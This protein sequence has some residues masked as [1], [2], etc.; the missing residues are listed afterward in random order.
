LG[1]KKEDRVRRKTRKTGHL[2][3]S[4]ART[5]GGLGLPTDPWWEEAFKLGVERVAAT[6]A[7]NSLDDAKREGIVGPKT[8]DR[9]RQVYL[10]KLSAIEG[11]TSKWH[12]EFPSFSEPAS[13]S[14]MMSELTEA[15]GQPSVSQHVPSNR[16]EVEPDLGAPSLTASRSISSGSSLI[17]NKGSNVPTESSN[18]RRAML[19]ELK[20][21]LSS[22]NASLT[23]V[24]TTQVGRRSSIPSKPRSLPAAPK[25]PEVPPPK[26]QNITVQKKNPTGV[27]STLME[28]NREFLE[29]FRKIR[30]SGSETT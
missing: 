10:E 18:V 24:P 9:L 28:L 19:D 16:D 15:I 17:G 30:K 23:K 8:Y 27:T 14:R 25:L 3:G 20:G 7:L 6:A 21:V 13:R 29:E 26:V 1:K 12:R 11:R 4:L 22:A 5:R 2:A